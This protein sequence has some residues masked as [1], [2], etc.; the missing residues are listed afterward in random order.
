M[1]RKPG[2]TVEFACELRPERT[3]PVIQFATMDR[4]SE[5]M[6]RRGDRRSGYG[7]KSGL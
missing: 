2:L 3:A 1:S 4:I 5:R 7:T 6:Q